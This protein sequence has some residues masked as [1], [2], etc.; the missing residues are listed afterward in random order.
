MKFIKGLYLLLSL[1][2]LSVQTSLA[3]PGCIGF[4]ANFEF[5]S[6][7]SLGPNALTQKFTN[8]SLWTDTNTH[9]LWSYGDASQ[10]LIEEESHTYIAKGAYNV[11]LYAF[12]IKAGDTV[13]RSTT[14]KTVTVDYDTCIIDVDFTYVSNGNYNQIDFKPN[15]T[16]YE[17]YDWDF[18]DGSNS[19]LKSPSNTFVIDGAYITCLEA[20]YTYNGSQ[21]CADTVCDTVSVFKPLISC[22]CFKVGFTVSIDTPSVLNGMGVINLTNTTT[23]AD[24]STVMYE[25]SYGDALTSTDTNKVHSHTYFSTTNTY[26]VCLKATRIKNGDTCIDSTCIIIE[27]AVCELNADF[28]IAGDTSCFLHHFASIHQGNFNNHRWTFGDSSSAKGVNVNHI[29]A[30]KGNYTVCHYVTDTLNSGIVCKDSVCKTITVCEGLSISEFNTLNAL[31]YPNPIGNQFFIE[32]S[33]TVPL[34]Y[35]ITDVLGKTV[36]EGSFTEKTTLNTANLANGF[37][38]LEISDAQKLVFRQKISK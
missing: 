27:V 31:V 35:T 1:V 18:G 7:T 20:S 30:K 28:S 17:T 10:K 32:T 26:T 21:K 9:Y 33:N 8:T 24:S 4:K 16:D 34:Q 37:Y 23:C 13:C 6:D 15:N 11:C 29:Y 36:K 22:D 19:L 12:K 3:Q 38:Y 14:C 2:L 25:W 5:E